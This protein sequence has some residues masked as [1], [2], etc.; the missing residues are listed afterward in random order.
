MKWILLT[1]LFMSSISHAGYKC[2]ADD[3]QYDG[4]A[5]LDA[6]VPTLSVTWKQFDK[7]GNVILVPAQYIDAQTVTTAKIPRANCDIKTYGTPNTDEY[8]TMTFH[9]ATGSNK[10]IEGS[11]QFDQLYK[12]A[13]YNEYSSTGGASIYFDMDWCN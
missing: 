13:S 9:C 1:I 5:V 10:W 2:Q 11:F 7:N 8:L 12:K 4:D 6:V 3:G